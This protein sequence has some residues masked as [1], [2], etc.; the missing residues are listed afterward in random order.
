[1]EICV[2]DLKPKLVILV[3]VL[4]YFSM[5][6]NVELMPSRLQI[7]VEPS[8]MENYMVIVAEKIVVIS[9]VVTKELDFT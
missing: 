7:V 9:T 3:H 4:H 8:E 5:A 6:L 1:M 2:L